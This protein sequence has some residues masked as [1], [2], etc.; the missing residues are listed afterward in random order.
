VICDLRFE[1]QKQE[2]KSFK[3]VESSGITERKL[4]TGKLIRER[5]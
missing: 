3:K 1:I 4:K 5:K 2:Q